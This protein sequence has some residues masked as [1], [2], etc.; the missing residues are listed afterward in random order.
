M[1]RRPKDLYLV[2]LAVGGNA[3]IAHIA[4]IVSVIC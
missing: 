4:H 1:G 3:E 2:H